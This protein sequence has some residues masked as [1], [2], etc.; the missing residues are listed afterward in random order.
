MDLTKKKLTV[1]FKKNLFTIVTVI[2][3]SLL[4]I[5]FA[6]IYKSSIIIEKNKELQSQA[7]RTKL[8][9]PYIV[10]ETLH[11]IDLGLRGYGISKNPIFWGAYDD[12][13]KKQTTTLNRIDTLLKKQGYDLKEF[14]QVKDSVNSYVKFCQLMRK[15]IENNKQEEFIQM[16]NEDRGTNVVVAYHKFYQNVITFE[17]KQI[18]KA[19]TTYEQTIQQIFLLQVLLIII[20]LPTL[21]VAIY[22]TK[23]T[24][25]LSNA[26]KKSEIERREIIEKQNEELERTVQTRT[27]ELQ[28]SKAEIL[29]QN[30]ELHQQQEELTV[31][32]DNL[33][34]T[35]KQLKNT[36][37]RLN[38]SIQYAYNIQQIILPKKDKLDSFFGK[39]FSLYLPKDIVSGDF[40]WFTLLEDNKAVFVLA[41]CTGHGVP[42]AFMSMV[43]CTLL[44]ETIKVKGVIEPARILKNLHAGVKNVLK[45]EENQNSDG[46]DISICLFEKD[47]INKS[48]QITFAGAKSS[49]FYKKEG[50]II[51]LNGDRISVGGSTERKREFRNQVISLKENDIIYFTSDGYI[52]QN[53]IKRERFG[54]SKFRELLGSIC[55][56]PILEQEQA[57]IDSLKEHQQEEEQRDD[58]SVVGIR[59]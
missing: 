49:V 53:N 10:A 7:E 19:Q 35:F 32:N 45:Q 58:I 1:I 6:F 25:S 56:L 27:L 37:D 46:M 48:Y 14:N 22:Y 3:I 16:F 13:I 31:I 2:I 41:D 33:D 23:K 17:D 9:I 29:T 12:A 57:I 59:L 30:E 38:K 5:N 54:S 28:N 11:G 21:A 55:T 4:L 51:Q 18:K 47:L 8:L 26:L 39:H 40:Y 43:G 44:Y 52:D 42:G 15:K 50:Q 36:S 20:C 34:I 24:F